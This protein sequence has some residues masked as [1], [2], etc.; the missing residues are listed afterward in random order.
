MDFQDDSVFVQSPV[1]YALPVSSEGIR[2]TPYAYGHFS[3]ASAVVTVLYVRSIV[4]GKKYQR[5]GVGKVFGAGA[6][7]TF[8][9]SQERKLVLV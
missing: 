1:I 4:G 8:R 7:T 9:S 6:W 3:K 5:I 2:A